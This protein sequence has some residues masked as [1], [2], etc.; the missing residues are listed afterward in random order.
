MDEWVEQR[1]TDREENTKFDQRLQGAG[2]EMREKALN[3]V[4]PK[5]RKGDSPSEG[6]VVRHKR[7]FSFDQRDEENGDLPAA[8]VKT[9]ADMEKKRLKSD[10]ERL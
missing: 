8:H 2:E 3:R 9:K 4:S 7:R 6:R 5:D 10:M 1:G